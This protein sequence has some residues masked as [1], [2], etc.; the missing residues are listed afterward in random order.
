MATRTPTHQLTEIDPAT[1]EVDSVLHYGSVAQCSRALH[2]AM[3]EEDVVSGERD[4]SWLRVEP[5]TEY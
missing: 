4:M 3:E 1:G 5:I 2:E